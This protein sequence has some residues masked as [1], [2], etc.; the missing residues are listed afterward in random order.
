MLE[1]EEIVDSCLELMGQLRLEPANR[2]SLM[3]QLAAGGAIRTDTSQARQAAEETILRTM[4]MIGS[5]RE[6]QFA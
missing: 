3:V 2:E 4:K 1:P 6:Y 5:T